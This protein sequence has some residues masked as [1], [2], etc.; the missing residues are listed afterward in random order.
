[1]G[2]CVCVFDGFAEMVISILE[3]EWISKY[4]QLKKKSVST[5]LST[6]RASV[7]TQT[8]Q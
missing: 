7:H 4:Q 5:A 8:T 1:M 2:V 6:A 3:V